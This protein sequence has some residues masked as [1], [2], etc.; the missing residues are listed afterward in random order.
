M[1]V[2]TTENTLTF[3]CVDCHIN[4]ERVYERS[5]QWFQNTNKLSD[6]DFNKFFQMS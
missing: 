2:R 5:S 4:Y 6:A 1:C 3:K